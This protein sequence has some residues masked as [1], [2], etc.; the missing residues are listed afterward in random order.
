[1]SNI[2]PSTLWHNQFRTAGSNKKMKMY[3]HEY[4]WQSTKKHE[5]VLPI[6]LFYG[7]DEEGNK[8]KVTVLCFIV[9]LL[10]SF[11]IMFCAL[12]HIVV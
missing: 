3:L 6:S 9:F 11:P 8:F 5:T 1:M 10:S 2:L 12:L 7:G 4:E